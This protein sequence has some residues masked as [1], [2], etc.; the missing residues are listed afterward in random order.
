MAIA[1]V[2]WVA[3]AGMW[4][5]LAGCA[6][7]RPPAA[8]AANPTSATAGT[9][10]IVAIA[11]PASPGC[12]TSLPKL[13][14]L[15]ELVSG[16]AGIAQRLGSRLLGALDLT[17]RFPDLQPQPPV[18]ALTDPA[19]MEPTAPPAVQAAAEIKAEEDAAP[20]KI[21]AIRYLATLGCGGCYEKVEEALLQAMS[22][23]TEEV[24]FEAVKA[25]ECRPDSCCKFCSS[26]SCC[27]LPVRKRLEELSNCDHE[28]S[29]RVR[30][31]ARL[32]LMCCGTKPLAADEVP[33][34]GPPAAP[35]LEETAEDSAVA[36]AV[37][38]NTTARRSITNAP[39][40]DPLFADMH[41][42]VAPPAP[43]PVI[44]AA[45][46]VEPASAAG[47][48]ALL[49]DASVANASLANALQPNP[50]STNSPLTN[51]ST[52]SRVVV[53]GG[54][55]YIPENTTATRIASSDVAQSDVALARVNGE[56][57]FASHLQPLIDNDLSRLGPA[58]RTAQAYRDSLQQQLLRASD[59][60]ILRQLAQ[61]EGVA[62][63]QQSASLT[64]VQVQAWF[65]RK[66]AIDETVP[67]TE[68][69]AYYQVHRQRFL[70]PARLRWESIVVLADQ[71]ANAEQAMI[72]ATYIKRR[73]Q[74][75]NISAPEFFNRNMVQAVTHPW[76]ELNSIQHPTTRGALETL[77]PGQISQ[78]MTVDNDLQL[79]RVLQ[80]EE[81]RIQSL[82]IVAPQIADE[83]LAQRRSAARQRF[84]SQARAQSQIWVAPEVVSTDALSADPAKPPVAPSDERL[85]DQPSISLLRSVNTSVSP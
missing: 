4:V 54:N 28:Q 62:S 45:Q 29:A 74:G 51:R 40:G 67:S 5:A 84:L 31:S 41:L 27:S 8:P 71:C 49:P 2:M 63:G 35:P 6:S 53:A 42:L 38:A 57:I 24:R 14:G 59:W 17:G 39:G 64:P 85:S 56:T 76:C 83:I 72:I 3:V 37:A 1:T 46:P 9:T 11:P 7:V 10:T 50:L 69:V 33:R 43:F 12:E 82:T 61:Q 52:E 18:L 77:A 80:R 78:V 25:L 66:T 15:P 70:L 13:L 34:E 47:P 65:E 26:S 60:I 21:M 75:E 32:A 68:I 23:C 30:R 16:V 79:V 58:Q 44:Q 55:G 81:E 73:A 48:S 20:Q 19:N 36:P 22:D